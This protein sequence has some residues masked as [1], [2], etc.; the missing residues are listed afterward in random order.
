MEPIVS[1]PLD[2]GD[3][4]NLAVS[5]TPL[6]SN[7]D[8]PLLR[9]QY[10]QDLGSLLRDSPCE[11]KKQYLGVAQGMDQHLMEQDNTLQRLN[12][13][14]SMIDDPLDNF[15]DYTTPDQFS[16]ILDQ[17]DEKNIMLTSDI[18]E[19]ESDNEETARPSKKRKAEPLR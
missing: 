4:N 8:E 10:M 9:S 18:T 15:L 17:V 14:E 7:S 3:D 2:V 16:S 13:V 19:F 6:S 12:T 1:E 11:E 5:L